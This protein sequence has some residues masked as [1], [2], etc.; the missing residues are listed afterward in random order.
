MKPVVLLLLIVALPVIAPFALG[1]IVGLGSVLI[2]LFSAPITLLRRSWSA[3][4]APSHQRRR[5][6]ALEAIYGTHRRD[7]GIDIIRDL[8]AQ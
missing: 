4:L 2:F 3:K 5:R 8:R 1:I 6:F 7:A